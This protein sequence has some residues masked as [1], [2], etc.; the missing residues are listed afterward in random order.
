ME[1]IQTLS[2][3]RRWVEG[4][5]RGGKRIG[6]V[7]SMG[8]LHE[9]HA[10]LMRRART[11]CDAVVASIFVNPT[12]FSPE[13]DYQSYP[14]DPEGDGRL[15][16]KS[17]VDALF[18]PDAGEL[19]PAGFRVKVSVPGLEDKLC[20]RYR[21][22]HFSGVAVIVLKLFNIV[23]P[24]RAYFGDKDYQQLLIIKRL[25][26]DLDLRV[27]VI[28]CPTVRAGDGVALSSRNEYLTPEERVSAPVLFQS[29][30]LAQSLA[31]QGE[32]RSSVLKE[33]MRDLISQRP[34][35]KVQY[36][37]ICH[38]ETLE[39]LEEVG[40]LALAALAVWVGKARLIDHRLLSR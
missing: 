24:D 19:Y 37:S 13:E 27:E 6:F 9:G 5:R 38:P 18:C 23:A 39:E 4:E 15:A 20:G 32:T 10:S 26:K 3:M 2:E 21:P 11:E 29:L 30:L 25:V 16:E 22:H 7:P 12:Q 28:G 8:K 36:I 14:R 17:G 35:T 34:H 40:E 33:R 1:R 31:D